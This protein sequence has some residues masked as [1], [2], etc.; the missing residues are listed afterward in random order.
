MDKTPAHISYLRGRNRRIS[1]YKK[2]LVEVQSLFYGRHYKQC[3]ALCEQLQ[4]PEVSRGLD[5]Q[6]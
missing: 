5:L 4:S 1:Y 2:E 3:I 6:G